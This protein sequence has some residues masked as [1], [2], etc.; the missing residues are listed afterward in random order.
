MSEADAYRAELEGVAFCE[1]LAYDHLTSLGAVYGPP[2]R[3]AG[4]ASSSTVWTVIRASVLGVPIEVVPH[5]ETAF[6]AALLAAAGTLHPDLAAAGRAMVASP[7]TVEP[8]AADTERLG[9]RYREFV[10]ALH[11]RGWISDALAAAAGT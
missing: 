8:V 4:G 10:A 1:R 9:A 11:R 5:A 7:R 2:L 6:G 3:S